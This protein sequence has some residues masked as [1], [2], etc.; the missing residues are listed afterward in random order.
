MERAPYRILFVEDDKVDQMAFERFAK[1]EHFPYEYVV[2]GSV[3]ETRQLVRATMFDA[4]V[5]DYV[6]GDGVA[7][8]VFDDLA[9]IPIIIVTGIGNEEIAV[10]AMKA[11]AYDYLIKD[12]EGNYLKTLTLTVENAIQRK[13]DELEL[14]AHRERLEE[15]VE[16]RTQELKK[17]IAERARAQEELHASLKE[18]EVLLRELHHRVKNNLQVI[19]SLL[20]LQSED[21]H[22]EQARDI[23]LEAQNRIRS[24]AHIH[25]Q[26]YQSSNLAE[27]DVHAY[28][29]QLAHTLLQSYG[30]PGISLVIDV[31][32]VA[33]D[34]DTA[35]SCGLIINELM[36]NSL[37]YAFPREQRPTDS[38]N[39]IRITLQ[40]HDAT[41]LLLQVNDN[42]IGF[43]DM[44]SEEH[45]TLSFGLR[46]V[47]MLARQLKGE[48]EIDGSD[49]TNIVIIFERPAYP[50]RSVKR[51]TV[52]PV[53][54]VS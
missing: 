23:F 38:P 11:G 36:S 12:Q 8:D 15:L 49:G 18:K 34:V 4:A 54:T 7:F 28:I 46:L 44:L 35:V 14:Q 53:S 52:P 41:T 3:E 43:P 10:K 27:L 39:E 30:K 47:K 22:D 19:S 45:H 13:H 1:R 37:K 31:T 42:G 25:E 24:M 50:P 2:A 20:D 26:L 48:I 51:T 32:D 5:I 40:S 21:I 29:T 16:Q 17:E 9:G 33:L 6:L